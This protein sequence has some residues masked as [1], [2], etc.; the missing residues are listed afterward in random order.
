MNRRL[1][2][3]T[4]FLC[5]KSSLVYFLHH[6]YRLLRH[7]LK[8]YSSSVVKRSIHLPFLTFRKYTV[9]LNSIFVTFTYGMVIP[10]LFIVSFI[11]FMFQYA[12]DKYLLVYNY[13]KYV[14][15]RS[16]RK[17]FTFLQI[18]KYAPCILMIFTARVLRY[19]SC[20]F[21]KP[22]E[23]K[24]FMGQ[25]TVCPDWTGPQIKFLFAFSSILFTICAGVD[26]Y[27]L[28]IRGK[29]LRKRY[30]FPFYEN[31]NYFDLLSNMQKK[32]WVAEELYI[33]DKTG[34]KLLDDYAL[35]KLL[36]FN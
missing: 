21:G 9:I 25:A 24:L 36:V 33:R 11:S 1:K 32:R 17:V 22:A 26:F 6:L 23:D 12:I 14:P 5:Q 2:V 10:V 3:G 35:S 20:V 34:I 19:N 27:R 15:L 29:T 30:Q 13:Y 31:C 8:F 4:A 16:D 7:F 28:G 18:T